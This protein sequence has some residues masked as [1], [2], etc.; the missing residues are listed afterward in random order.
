MDLI[1]Q[2]NRTAFL[3]PEFLTWLWYRTE[4]SGEIFQVDGQAQPFEVWFDDRLVVGSTRVN[5]QEN[6]FKGG[7]PSSSLEART[8]LRLGKL[9]TQARLRIIRDSLEWGFVFNATELSTSGVK[10][11]PVLAK[12]T[13]EKLY[14]RMYLVEQLDVMVKGLFGQFVKLRLSDDW[15]TKYLSDIQT[16]VGKQTTP[17]PA[18]RPMT[19]RPATPVR[20]SDESIEVESTA[21]ESAD[22]AK[23][24]EDSKAES[25]PTS[26]SDADESIDRNED[27]PP[28][29][30]PIGD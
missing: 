30:D 2:I 24:V 13:D 14:E 17:A 12:E 28:W 6:F 25:H 8:A 20:E 3:G 18:T 4:T 16:W 7:H 9:A 15:N 10:L 29:E 19:R 5:A 22:I 21:S 23:A 27:L 26:T 1:E 11:P